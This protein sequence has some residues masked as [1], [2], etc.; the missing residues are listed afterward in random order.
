MIETLRQ[1]YQ[2]GQRYGYLT[3]YNDLPKCLGSLDV[4]PPYKDTRER[5][6]SATSIQRESVNYNFLERIAFRLGKNNEQ[7]R[8]E[9]RT[10]QRKQR[11][12]QRDKILSH[13]ALLFTIDDW[14]YNTA[15]PWLKEDSDEKN[16][17]YGGYIKDYV[18]GLTEDNLLHA[19]LVSMRV[20]NEAL[21]EKDFIALFEERGFSRIILPEYVNRNI[22]GIELPGNYY[23]RI[24]PELFLYYAES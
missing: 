2:K 20:D 3:Q 12:E 18:I 6:I 23:F 5:N 24:P 7:K 8:K 14:F 10:Q 22:D 21:A 17:K 1:A 11:E 19:S 4:S 16:G 9:L 15:S 13:G